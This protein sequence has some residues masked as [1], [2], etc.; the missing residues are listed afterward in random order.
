MKNTI[1]YLFLSLISLTSFTQQEVSLP[2]DAF[3]ADEDLKNASV[4]LSI[5]DTQSGD[6]VFDHNADQTLT[7]ASTLKLTT[8]ITALELFGSEHQFETSLYYTGDIEEGI[9]KGDL[10][11]VAGGDPCLG[12]ND[13]LLH[14]GEFIAQWASKVHSLGIKQIR[15]DIKLDLSYFEGES[16]AGSTSIEDSGNYYAA[17]AH[18]LSVFD[19]Q[20][21]I[22]LRSSNVAGG[23]VEVVRVIPPNPDMK[24]VCEL[25]ASNIDEDRAYIY[26]IP[27]SNERVIKGTIPKGKKN[28]K[29][30]GD[31]PNPA[32][33][34]KRQLI[35]AIRGKRINFVQMKNRGEDG[36]TMEYDSF[37]RTKVT[38]V[39]S[40]PLH[41]IVSKCLYKSVNTYA[42]CLLKHLGKKHKNEGSYQ[43]GIETLQ[44]HW[45]SKGLTIDGWFQEDGS[46][47][48]RAN[49]ISSQHIAKILSL[50][51]MKDEVTRGFKQLGDNENIKVK[52]GYIERVRSYAGYIQGKGERT[53]SF[54]IIVNNYS[55][56]PGEMRRKI[57]KFFASFKV[58]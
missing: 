34:L 10:L 12:A 4:S 47:L 15:G 52:S 31:I 28:Y 50:T 9:L 46:G 24:I 27:G 40:P 22:T 39:S 56:S 14:Y 16:L 17:G 43:A 55:C 13:F 2:F 38:S 32:E 33:L 6:R 1:L 21:E 45:K 20:C 51:S 26:G 11:I 8:A 53:Y 3:L 30:K 18:S 58:E 25:T 48:S 42:D 36:Q 5:M 57:E 37:K 49:G 54:C 44:S 23:P 35:E 41:E 7:P 29:I 19:N